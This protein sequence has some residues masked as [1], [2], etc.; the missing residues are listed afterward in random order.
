[1]HEGLGFLAPKYHPKR[2][3]QLDVYFATSRQDWLVIAK[4]KMS[5]DQPK[6]LP[7]VDMNFF[8][9]IFY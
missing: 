9:R 2:K 7:R 3:S 5:S 6:T 1:M 4:P 8:N